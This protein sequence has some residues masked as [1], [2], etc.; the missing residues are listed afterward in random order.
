MPARSLLHAYLDS[1]AETARWSTEGALMHL[2]SQVWRGMP[3]NHAVLMLEPARRRTDVWVIEVT[4]GDPL[5]VDRI[6]C[7]NLADTTGARVAI[8]FN[9]PNQ[10]LWGMVEDDLI[11][12]SF[13]EFLLTGDSDWPLLLPMTRAVIAAM[14]ALEKDGRFVVTGASKRGWTTW[15]A[16]VSGDPRIIGIAPRVYDNLNIPHQMEHQIELWGDY[17]P[18]IDDYTRRGLQEMLSHPEGK[19]LLAAVD[20]F[21]HLTELRAPVY[22][23]LGANDGYWAIDAAQLYWNHIPARRYLHVFPNEL[24]GIGDACVDR[25]GLAGFVCACAGLRPWPNESEAGAACT[26]YASAD[27]PW[28]AESV[29]STEIPNSGDYLAWFEARSSSHD[30]EPEF[31]FSTLPV[32]EPRR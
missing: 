2:V 22:V 27:R 3:W 20:P 9:I 31:P 7:Q 29:W 21:A 11:A 16:G 1:T 19:R 17:S 23:I 8:L 13:S 28:F 10:P 24:H 18:R 26:W 30:G 25:P 32:I 14:D 4:G 15:L 5:E 12:H 6:R